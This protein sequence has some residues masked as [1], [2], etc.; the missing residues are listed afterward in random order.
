MEVL[1]SLSLY[2]EG[3]DMPFLLIGG[4]AANVYGISRQT[5]D[6]DLV[7][8]LSSKERWLVLLGK[9]GYEKGQDDDRF[10]RFMPHSLTE[11][12]I[13]LMFVDDPTFAKLQKDSIESQLGPAQV[14]VVSP[15][16]LATLK[17][18]ALKYYQEHRFVKDYTDLLALLRSGQTGL[19]EPELEAL[20]GRYATRELFERIKRDCFEK[21]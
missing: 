7:V 19:S 18:H 16:H 12:P 11:W 2:V 6:L 4:Q 9:L 20:C 1:R 15:R 5:G 21:P 17:I 10:A 3:K 13:D 8:K 14:R